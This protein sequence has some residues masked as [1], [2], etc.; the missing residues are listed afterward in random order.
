MNSLRHRDPLSSILTLQVG[1]LLSSCMILK[2]NLIKNF[3]W[4]VSGQ[5]RQS[6]FSS[7]GIRVCAS[8]TLK[9][10]AE[11]NAY[12]YFPNLTHVHETT[13]STIMSRKC[14]RI[15]F[16]VWVANSTSTVQRLSQKRVILSLPTC[17]KVLSKYT[18]IFPK[19]QDIQ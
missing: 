10:S 12:N 9:T 11:R 5:R 16:I 19:R 14:I 13:P 2:D 1:V 18:K 17:A 3:P 8:I 15:Y 7:P 6:S 4:G